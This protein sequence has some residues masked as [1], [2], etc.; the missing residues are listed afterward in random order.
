MMRIS[1]SSKLITRGNSISTAYIEVLFI[2]VKTMKNRDIIFNWME[3][4]AIQNVRSTKLN[5]QNN[6]TY[7]SQGFRHKDD[8]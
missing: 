1:Q 6:N 4:T 2:N 8:T 7:Y 3:S 5:L